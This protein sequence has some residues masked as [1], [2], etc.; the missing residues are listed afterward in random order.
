VQLLRLTIKLKKNKNMENVKCII[1]LNIKGKESITTMYNSEP[2]LEEIVSAF[3]NSLEAHRF[4]RKNIR[5][6]M[7]SVVRDENFID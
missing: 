2:T 5:K 4:N 3:V 7:M 1:T 6:Y